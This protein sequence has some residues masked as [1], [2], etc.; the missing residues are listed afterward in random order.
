MNN[1]HCFSAFIILFSLSR[2][3]GARWLTEVYSQIGAGL[4]SIS[5]DNRQNENLS[6]TQWCAMGVEI[7][8]EKFNLLDWQNK[9]R[10]FD[11]RQ[12]CERFFGQ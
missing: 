9:I 5:L 12:K 6:N 3:V 1:F 8:G 11:A 10:M 7:D 2:E 4:G